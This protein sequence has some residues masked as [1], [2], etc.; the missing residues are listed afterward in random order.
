MLFFLGVGQIYLIS[1]LFDHEIVGE[2]FLIQAFVVF[3][4][5]LGGSS[6]TIKTLVQLDSK[7]PIFIITRISKT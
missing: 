6:I 7:R 3:A 2:F 4:L 1:A 5:A